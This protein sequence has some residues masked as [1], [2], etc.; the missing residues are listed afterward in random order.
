[1]RKTILLLAMIVSTVFSQTVLEQACD[2]RHPVN[3]PNP[4]NEDK[5][6]GVWEVPG[7]KMPARWSLNNYL[8]G[9]L[10]MLEEDGMPYIRISER[11][12]RQ[13]EASMMLG[14][15]AVQAGP[16]IS[17]HLSGKIRGTNGYIG[18]YIYLK[19]GGWIVR[20]LMTVNNVKEWIDFH[21]ILDTDVKDVDYITLCIVSCRNS[22]IEVGNM[23]IEEDP[24]KEKTG[25]SFIIS[26]DCIKMTMRGSGS[27]AELVDKRN[28][29]DIIAFKT[30]MFIA[31]SESKG[32]LRPDYVT[33]SGDYIHVSFDNESRFMDLFLK[34]YPKYFTL[35][36]I[37]ENLGDVTEVKFFNLC[38][39]LT[40]RHGNLMNIAHGGDFCAFLFACNIDTNAETGPQSISGEYYVKTASTPDNKGLSYQATAYREYKLLG[41]KIAFA[42]L[43]SAEA[44]D[45][46]E[47]IEIEQGLPHLTRDGIWLRKHPGR[48]A[49]YMMA[50]RVTEQNVDEV[51]DFAKGGFG[52]IEMTDGWYDSSPTYEPHRNTYPEGM[53][54]LKA[55]ADKIH[56]AGLLFGLHSMQ[57][58][59]GWGGRLGMLDKH[60]SPVADSRLLQKQFNTLAKDID[61]KATT[62]EVTESLQDWPEK[63]G[64]LNINGEIVRYKSRTDKAFMDCARG[65]RSTYRHSY[66][67]G[68]KIGLIV[69][70]WPIW[71]GCIYAPDI[72]STLFDEIVERQ[73][74]ILNETK[75]DMAYF[76][77]GEEW[78][79]QPPQ[80]RNTGRFINALQKRLHKPVF[81]GGNMLY[82]PL[83]WHS[84]VRGAPAFDP[85]YYGR[86]IYTMRFKGYRPVYHSYNM[87][88]GDV[89]W[90]RAHV[91]SPSTN[92]A[93]PD[94][95]ELLCL[96]AA[97]TSSPISVQIDYGNYYSNK[98]MNE[99]LRYIKLCDKI[100]QEQLLP[101]DVCKELYNPRKR[102]ALLQDGDSWNI[103]PQTYSGAFVLHANRELIA[104]LGQVFDNPYSE[105]IPI[106]RVRA[107]P[108]VARP[109]AKGN[110]I[111][112]DFSKGTLF[113]PLSEGIKIASASEKAPDGT[114]AIELSC[115]NDA[116][117][118]T[119]YRKFGY[120]FDKPISLADKRALCVW[121]KGEEQGGILNVQLT[122]TERRGSVRENYIDLNFRGWKRFILDRPEDVR[123]FDYT[124][125]YGASSPLYRQYQYTEVVGVNLY[126]NKMP[127]KKESRVLVGSIEAL[128]EYECS[129]TN[130]VIS[131]NGKDAVLPVMLEPNDYAEWHA[132]GTINVFERDGGLIVSRKG[133]QPPK[134][135]PSRNNV[136]LKAKSSGEGDARCELTSIFRGKTLFS[137]KYKTPAEPEPTDYRMLRGDR[138]KPRTMLGNMELMPVVPA[139]FVSCSE[140]AFESDFDFARIEADAS[141]PAAM[142]ISHIVGQGVA[143]VKEEVGKVIMDFANADGF[144]EGAGNIYGKYV[145]GSGIVRD[146]SGVHAN[147]ALASIEKAPKG[148]SLGGKGIIFRGLN[149]SGGNWAAKGMTFAE[150]VDLSEFDRVLLS[151]NGDGGGEGI[152]IQ[153]W[154]ETGKYFDWTPRIDFTGWRTICLPLS[155]AMPGF[156]PKR[157]KCFIVLFNNLPMYNEASVV[158]ADMRGLRKGEKFTN[159]TGKPAGDVPL[160]VVAVEA[161]GSKFALP[162]EIGHNEHALIRPDGKGG[163]YDY[164]GKLLKSFEVKANLRVK[165]KGNHV[166]VEG[167]GSELSS[168]QV[169]VYA[170]KEN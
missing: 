7:G 27:V 146:A 33:F 78:K 44:L 82:T 59:V 61:D 155:A 16:G 104:P 92:A 70:C 133:P 36:L 166:K 57:G 139:S 45:C 107:L 49:S 164:T 50:G 67:A 169:K 125:P 32:D 118:P 37:R 119:N 108:S 147:G 98:R 11:N 18:A 12:G 128:T 111:I 58:M 158:F 48:T 60:I 150:C 40:E 152:R 105:Q 101:E 35:S 126:L 170:G 65:F 43:P 62:I 124:W 24:F 71:G 138:G 106:L 76:D 161:N 53:K 160:K 136:E 75:A 135:A 20:K 96:K 72:E 81:A 130:P 99:M 29:K 69:N 21:A 87:F 112:A 120:T 114:P 42:A 168:M 145:N 102:H 117:T 64:D 13:G 134:F 116:A 154:D 77:A 46:A 88:T 31:K 141:L 63:D 91:W 103:V 6:Y 8:T 165:G 25:K 140:G 19:T 23:K 10:E 54:N 39:S 113:K 149:S 3:V 137:F 17:Y 86:D 144:A 26:N 121:V 167:V 93:T 156:N 47:N 41:A 110:M 5:G 55:V 129:I 122:S 38:L 131:V 28:G 100:K 153:F 90:Y 132:D 22:T 85:M 127:P 159:E 163:L 97:A 73:A 52:C 79:P 123:F 56:A 84:I 89:G 2:F 143:K 15:R 68:Q 51:I 95:L 4:V 157:V 34:V 142:V 80:W 14:N 1:M 74:Y 30:Q 115:V 151:V 94:E 83:S 148:R 109:A 162:V 9:K 66:K